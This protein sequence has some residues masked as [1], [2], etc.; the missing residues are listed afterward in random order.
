MIRFVR[1]ARLAKGI[2]K[3]EGSTMKANIKIN[4]G[5]SRLAM[6]GAVLVLGCHVIACFWLAMAQFNESNWLVL[7]LAGLQGNGEDIS[8]ESNNLK[9]YFVSLYFTI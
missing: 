3:M 9:V 5:L 8:V 7:K 2:K 4:A 6:F 1:L